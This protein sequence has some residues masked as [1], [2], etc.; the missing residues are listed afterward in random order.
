MLMVGCV[1]DGDDGGGGKATQGLIIN[2]NSFV[3]FV[4]VAANGYNKF[5]N[6]DIGIQGL[7]G[8][9]YS[10]QQNNVYS[11]NTIDE[12]VDSTFA[13][14][15]AQ[16]DKANTTLADITGLTKDLLAGR[17]YAFRAYLPT[18]SNV[19]SGIKF[20]ISG[21]CTATAIRYEA[22]IFQNGAMVA[23]GTTRATALN[24][25]VGNVTAVT[26]A[27]CIIEGEITVNAAGTLTVQFADNAGTNTSSVLV[28]ATFEVVEITN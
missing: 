16:F 22:L 14:N 15:K 11:G 7:N 20:A 6:C 9:K 19:A 4:G 23:P 1:F 8:G 3:T 13:S 28:G 17:K 26:V 25:T 12:I 2:S 24:T 5:R 10:G 21:T 18:T 27:T